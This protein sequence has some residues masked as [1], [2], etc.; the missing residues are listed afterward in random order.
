MATL[1]STFKVDIKKIIDDA[2]SPMIIE[3]FFNCYIPHF[4]KWLIFFRIF[5]S[6][7]PEP[8]SIKQGLINDAKYALLFSISVEIVYF[9]KDAIWK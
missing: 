8:L 4:I 2:G 5:R 9:I 7:I 1:P 6:F 3:Y